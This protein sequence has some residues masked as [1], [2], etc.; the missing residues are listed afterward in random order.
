MS[1]DPQTAR[2]LADDLLTS[3]EQR[4]AEQIAYGVYDVTMTGAEAM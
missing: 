2:A 3:I 4:E 1:T